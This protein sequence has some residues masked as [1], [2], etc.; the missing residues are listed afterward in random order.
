MTVAGT[1]PGLG[2]RGS[3]STHWSPAPAPSV[4]VCK[5]RVIVLAMQS[6]CK[7]ELKL[8]KRKTL[9]NANART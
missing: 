7:D 9:H 8:C 2:V 6:C 5:V 1:S 3:K 4:L